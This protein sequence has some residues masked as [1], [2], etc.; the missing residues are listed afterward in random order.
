MNTARRDV[1]WR[2]A[3]R[4]SFVVVIPIRNLEGLSSTPKSHTPKCCCLVPR[5]RQRKTDHLVPFG[6]PCRIKVHGHPRHGSKALFGLLSARPIDDKSAPTNASAERY[7]TDARPLH[8]DDRYA[9]ATGA[10]ATAFARIVAER[11]PGT[12][13]L[14]VKSSRS[15][16]PLV[17]SAGKVV[18]LLA[19]PTDMDTSGGIGD[20]ASSTAYGRASHEHG[21]DAGSQ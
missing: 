7:P 5:Q 1:A 2:P 19:G 20:S 10:V 13:W 21:A 6:V 9:V 17:V 18:R 15:D 11:Y 14:P 4:A 12:S 16:D 8:V 3:T